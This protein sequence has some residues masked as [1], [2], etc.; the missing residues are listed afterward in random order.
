MATIY[1]TLIIMGHKT[2]DEVPVTLKEQVRE[3]LIQLEAEHL[4]TD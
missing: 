2:Y 1:T 4:I 3:Q